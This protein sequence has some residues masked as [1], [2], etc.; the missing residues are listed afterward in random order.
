MEEA[1]ERREGNSRDAGERTSDPLPRLPSLSLPRGGGAIRGLGEKLQIGDATGT[2]SLSIPVALSPA[3]NGFGPS[4][5]LAYDSGR[6]NGLFGLGW[7]VAI[8]SI[9]RKTDKGLPRYRDDRDP[10]TF[11]LA[12]A[13]DLVPANGGDESVTRYLP[14]VESSFLLVERVEG[15]AGRFWRTVSRENVVTTFGT[16][17]NSRIADPDDPERVFEWL[18][19]RTYDDRGNAIVYEYAQENLDE[20]PGALH[21]EHRHGS[22]PFTNRH[23]KRILYGNRVP[24]APGDSLPHEDQWLFC[25]VFDYG[26]HDE[27]APELTADRPWRAREDPFSSYRAGFEVRTYRLC[28]RILMFHRFAELGPEP[29]LVR[30]TDFTFAASRAH[31]TLTQVRQ[32]GYVL[33]A[34]A[35]LRASFPPLDLEY[36]RPEWDAT[37][38]TVDTGSLEGAPAG[39][40]GARYRLVDLDGEGLSGVLTEQGGAWWYKRSE[41]GGAFAP[42]HRV[43]RLPSLA[44]LSAG[45]QQLL[46]LDGDG[47]LALVDF[48]G[49][50][51]GYFERTPSGSWRPFDT[52]RSLPNIPWDD[53]NLRFVDLDGDGLADVLLTENDVLAWYP[54][55]AGEGF[56]AKRES[57]KPVDEALGPRVVFADGTQS[58]YLADM[59]GDGLQDLVRIRNGEV[60][61]WPNLGHG[62]FGARV[63]MSA[64]PRLDH[65]DLFDQRRVHLADVDGSGTTDIVY[66]REGAA[67]VYI[68]EAGN[69]FAPPVRIPIPHLDGLRTVSVGDI[70]GTGTSALVWSSV[71]LDGGAQWRYIDL[72]R[73]T[74]SHLLE[75]VRNNLGAETRL[76]YAPSTRFYLEDRRAGRPWATRLPFVVHVVEQV[77]VDDLAAG[78]HHVT[79][80]AYHHGYFDGAEREFRGFGHVQEWSNESFPGAAS[81]LDQPAQRS[82]TWFHTGAWIEGASLTEAFRREWWNGDAA[83]WRPVDALL[84][85][86]GMTASEQR[87]SARALRGRPLRREVY[88]E[89]GTPESSRPYS[90][91]HSTY[92]VTMLQPKGNRPHA[93]FHVHTAETLNAHYERN[94]AD[95]RLTHDVVIDVDP[96]GNVTAEASIA[97]ARRVPKA[98]ALVEQGTTTILY[99]TRAYSNREEATWR[100]I[101]VP[102]QT[103]R[104]ELAPPATAGLLDASK[105]RDAFA[106]AASRRL[107][108]AQRILYWSD[109]LT[110]ALPLGDPGRRALA[111]ES[112]NAVFTAG[113]VATIFGPRVSDALLESEGGYLRWP[114]ENDGLWWDRSGVQEIDAAHFHTPIA[115]VDPWGRRTSVDYDGHFLLL[116][117]T[118]DALPAPLTNSVTAENDYRALAPW[119]T[120]D[121]NGNETV[122]RFD[123]LGMVVAT[124]LVG[125]AGEGD[126][127]DD[128]TTRLSYDLDSWRLTGTPCS[129]RTEARERHG[130]ANPRWQVS[131]SFSDGNGHE[132]L[133]KTQAGGGRWAGTGR[134]VLNNRGNPVRR[135]EAYFAP[136]EGFEALPVGVSSSLEYDPLDR[137]V[138]TS[139]PNGT[140]TRVVFAAWDQETWDENDT[141]LESQWHLDRQV[142]PAGD[143]ER[144]ADAL[145]GAHANTPGLAVL[146]PRSRAVVTVARSNAATEHVVRTRYDIEGRQLSLHDARGLEVLRQHYDL[147]G[148]KMGSESADAG[149][150]RTL[151][152]VEGKTLYAWDGDGVNE[153]RTRIV[154]DEIE[155]PIERWVRATST[156]VEFLG[157]RIVYGERHPFAEA[158][159]LRLQVFRTYDSAGVATNERYNVH[160]NALESTRRLTLDF[161]RRAEWQV[162]APYVDIAAIA[163]AAEPLLR[164][165]TLTTLT[166]YDALNR[167]TEVTRADGSIVTPRYDEANFLDG[168]DVR[169]RGAPAATV[170]LADVDH[171]A[172]GQRTRVVY[173]NGVVSEYDYDPLTYRLSRAVTKRPA[174]GALPAAKLQD[175]RYTYDPVGHVVAVRD[176]SQQTVFFQNAVAEPHA[177]YEYDA[178]YRLTRAE[179]RE[180]AA[181]AIG[182]QPDHEELPRQRLPH[183]NDL[184]AVR[185]YEQRYIYDLSGNLEHTQHSSGGVVHWT[186]RCEYSAANNRLLSSSRPGDPL[187]PPYSVTYGHDG[188][189]NMTSAPGILGLTFDEHEHLETVDLG[190]GGRAYYS[191]DSDGNRVRK[192]IE[193]LDG[194][195]DERIYF[196]DI[197]L[198][199]ARA[200]NGTLLFQRDTLRVM[201]HERQ[202]ALIETKLVEAGALVPSAPVVRFQLDNHLGSA[203]LELNAAG[204]AISYEEYYPFGETAYHS[205]QGIAETSLKRYR[206]HGRERD[207]ETGLYY[208][209]ARYYIPW[210]GRW[211]SPDPAGTDADLNAYAF[212]RNN[213][214]FFSDPTGMWPSWKTVAIVAA[215][216]VVGTVVTVATAG[217]AAPLAAGAVASLG[218]SGAA[219]TVATGVVVGAVAGTAGGAASELTRQVAS[220]ERVSGGKI[221]RAAGQ[222]ALVGGVTGG[223]ASG[224]SAFA[225][226]A[227]GVAVG[228]AVAERVAPL[229]QR[230]G[231]AVSRVIPSA[232]RTAAT[233]VARAVAAGV[234]QVPRAL[235]AVNAAG[236]RVGIAVARAGFR[237]ATNLARGSTTAAV[238]T[239]RGAAVVER[240]AQ[241]RSIASSLETVRLFRGTKT[242]EEIAQLRESGYVLS[243]AARGAYGQAIREGQSVAQ[244]LSAGRLA[245]AAAHENQ[246]RVWGTLEQ[247]SQA[248]G[249]WGHELSQFGP[250]S[251]ISFTEKAAATQVFAEGGV[252]IETNVLRAV[253]IPQTIEG[254]TEAE[255]LV[256]NLIRGRILK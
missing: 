249:L 128:P 202:I 133:K 114:G 152:D 76:R 205:A 199:R 156:S 255:F 237:A 219:G 23:P 223:I 184:A 58:V 155:R 144:R 60:C 3:R 123:A 164:A 98:P 129:V 181:F 190:G 146:D 206:Y 46:D 36:T 108:G 236:E 70:L 180:L 40:D 245:S 213:P 208:F 119:R 127:L 175:L 95:P 102:F 9:R 65:F 251:L 185:R 239:A 145:A 254:A 196:D 80:Y 44:N 195:T 215:V 216:V 82:E 192:V 62:E 89:D 198:F 66:L 232:V 197:E 4:L 194:S 231:A 135:Y 110:G 173:G 125:K 150:S 51:A 148:R 106:L 203:L 100:R 52:F 124:A 8:P 209:G 64:C 176:D 221:L 84:D 92:A 99:T 24:L 169:G 140:F 159:N 29:V 193:R 49:P 170:F 56:A 201:D 63:S 138:R 1:G 136:D 67:H 71:L 243:D 7:G 212:V 171:D 126:T 6:G 115:H 179:G 97:Y 211:A 158:R 200:A 154:H 117:A 142:L 165:E 86:A 83:E 14:R 90:V 20:V 28:R 121:A 75:L 104:F 41:G 227:R 139:H 189:G 79:R 72:L 149:D 248:H 187:V 132:I 61:Y 116:V 31:A 26:D 47:R 85:T 151:L 22:S 188:F 16:T 15:P 172:K 107:L 210:L 39:I 57:H 73:G 234:R 244:S 12:G 45:R 233:P 19:D 240:F 214:I 235:G 105:L 33:D 147:T 238:A 162:L 247:Y 32:S 253:A 182:T 252:V 256:P 228:R 101:G 166:A 163:A 81:P 27:T 246:L 38:R 218:L 174:V 42:P 141:V 111:R 94:A 186:R 230:T 153:R 112:Y 134:V 35:Y 177:L 118:H 25:V 10:D 54:S 120:V 113:M 18:I 207:D 226:S 48:S 59:S 103:R 224:V 21:E 69:S 220:G 183:V 122:V 222:G 55:L 34:G 17:P 87:E 13:E 204:A 157:E 93:V 11:L 161:R 78:H 241:T 131:V 37:V 77:I 43:E 168:I 229:A 160:G 137:L 191:Y 5:S 130:A 88:A 68:N 74:K 2:A 109:D 242:V 167:V 250:R 178:L 225:S 50:M 91:T 96:Y 143:P 53:D 217:A 30:S